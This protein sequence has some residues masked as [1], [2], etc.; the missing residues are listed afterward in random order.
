MLRNEEIQHRVK[1]K[2]DVLHI[3]N[4]KKASWIGISCLGTAL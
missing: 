4:R 3:T 1:K 2:R